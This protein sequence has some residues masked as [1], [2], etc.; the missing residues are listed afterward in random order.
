MPRDACLYFPHIE[1][2]DQSW[3]RS[4]LLF[5]D[6]L[7]TIVPD[8][9]ENPYQ[10]EDLSFLHGEGILSAERLSS[11]KDEVGSASKLM[12]DNWAQIERSVKFSQKHIEIAKDFEDYHLMHPEKMT[13]ELIRTFRQHLKEN[14]PGV[15][16]AFTYRNT[17]DWEVTDPKMATAYMAILANE[18]AATRKADPVTN[19]SFLRVPNPRLLGKKNAEDSEF[20]PRLLEIIMENT[21]IDPNADIR[22]LVAFKRDNQAL[23]NDFREELSK[24]RRYVEEGYTRYDLSKLYTRKIRPKV[25]TLRGSLTKSHLQWVG[26]GCLALPA[27]PDSAAAVAELFG[28]SGNLALAATFGLV[29]T[30]V[31]IGAHQSSRNALRGEPMSYLATIDRKFT[32][33]PW[34]R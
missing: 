16:E 28:T 19:Y 13:D 27:V 25:E 26:G 31:G 8:A 4:Y 17:S 20:E 32:L 2:R 7:R 9:V 11:Y 14:A 12:I 6:E 10:I 21:I 34:E 5:W 1:I 33:P 24:F 3:T 30:G 22:K 29:L 15:G 18:I 23:F